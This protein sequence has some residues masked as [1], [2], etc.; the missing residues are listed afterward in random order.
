VNLVKMLSVLAAGAALAT[1]ACSNGDDSGGGCMTSSVGPPQ[2]LYPIPG[3]ILS[4]D[5]PTWLVVANVG[6]SGGALMLVPAGGG[7]AVQAGSLG[8]APS[9]LPSPSNTAPP[10]QNV[11]AAALPILTE[12]TKYSVVFTANTQ[13]PCGPQQSSGTIGSFTTQ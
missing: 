2:L 12:S 7:S 5:N 1:A 13:P 4:T 9:P 11:E 6:G 10:G 3:T 8:A